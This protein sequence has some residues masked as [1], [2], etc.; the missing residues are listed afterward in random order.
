MSH[1]GTITVRG[2]A[3][4]RVTP[5]IAVWSVVVE[6]H[7]RTER[8]VFGQ[9]SDRLNTLFTTL[10]DSATT[11]EIATRPIHVWPEWSD[12]GGRRIGYQGRGTVVIRGPIDEAARLGQLALDSGVP[13]VDGPDYV[14]G[15]LVRI[16][17]E[18][19]GEAVV[20]ARARAMRMAEAAGRT[21]GPVVGI[22]DEGVQTSISHEAFGMRT[23]AMRDATADVSAPPSA[24]EMEDIQTTAVV[25]FALT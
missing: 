10:R 25:T 9:C 18:L 11:A 14:V 8:E 17:D 5:D 23:M 16:Q 6:G 15:E 1:E 3:S 21:L 20:A 2:T 22:T 13:R 12:T 4:R 24:P 19:A 7:A